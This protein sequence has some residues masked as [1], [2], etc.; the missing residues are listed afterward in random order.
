VALLRSYPERGVDQHVAIT[1][2]KDRRAAERRIVVFCEHR[3]NNI[4]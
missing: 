4:R 2:Y 1:R 3:A